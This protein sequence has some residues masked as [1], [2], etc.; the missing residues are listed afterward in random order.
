LLIFDAMHSTNVSGILVEN[1]TIESEWLLREVKLDFYLP[2]NVSDP[3]RLDLLLI[4]DGQ[5]MKEL[6]LEAMLEQLYAAQAIDPLVAVAIHAGE[7]RKME[8]GVAGHPDYLGR[9]TKAGSYQSFILKEVLP[10]IRDTYH[11]PSF[12]QKAFAG[13]SLGGL[14]ALDIVWRY[15]G[16]FTTAAVFSGSLWWRSIDQTEKTYDDH[17]HRIMHQVIRNGNYQPGLKFFFQCGNKD[18]TKDRNQNGIIDSIDD[19]QDLIKEL[20]AK[21]YDPHKDIHYLEMP[22]GRHDIPTWARAM[23]HFLKWIKH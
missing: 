21:G 1:N 4:N 8:Y 14:S 6:G 5:N 23:P 16:E 17:L 18:E 12:R 20:I 7:E 2:R 9:G 19:T 3:S 10:F 13:F 15:P 11:L 22:D